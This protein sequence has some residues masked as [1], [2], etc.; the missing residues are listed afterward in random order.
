[1]GKSDLLNIAA[2]FSSPGNRVF[3]GPM[4]R[5]VVAQILLLNK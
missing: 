3:T 2:R 1:M 5:K 4:A